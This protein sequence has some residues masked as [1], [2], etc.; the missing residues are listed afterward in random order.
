MRRL[1][2]LQE[3]KHTAKKLPHHH[4]SYRGLWLIMLAFGASLLLITRAVRASENLNVTAK[5]P[6]P[7]PTTA[8]IIDSPLDKTSTNDANILVSGSCPVITPAIIVVIYR[9]SDLIGA[10]GCSA[11]G[12]FFATTHLIEGANILTPIIQT[13]TYDYGPAGQPVTIYYQKP[14]ATYDQN[15]PVVEALKL[16]VDGPFITYKIN[17]PL[18]WPIMITGGRPPYY[19]TINWG[20]NQSETL[21]FNSSGHQQAKH[22]Y[23]K[24]QT[25]L[26]HAQ[27]IDALGDSASISVAAVTSLGSAGIN[28]LGSTGATIKNGDLSFSNIVIIIYWVLAAIILAFWLGTRYEKL[29]LGARLRKR[30]RI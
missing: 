22:V 2:K 9:D 19:L 20:D 4:T 24:S 5:V 1:L 8:A 28:G 23:T 29:M 27:A 21:H 3:H 18:T 25:Y 30:K 11:A 26:I 17:E 15:K 14:T 6:A 12:Q 13:I 7:I 16:Q 10:A